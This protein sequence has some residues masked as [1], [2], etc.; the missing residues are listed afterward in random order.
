MSATDGLREDHPASGAL[1]QR[2]AVFVKTVK[3]PCEDQTGNIRQRW[4]LERP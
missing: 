2:D 3:N 4:S 1:L